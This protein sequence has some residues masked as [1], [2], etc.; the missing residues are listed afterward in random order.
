L[1]SVQ[2]EP[3]PVFVVALAGVHGAFVGTSACG[4]AVGAGAGVGLAQADSASNNIKG[5]NHIDFRNMRH[6]L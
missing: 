2:K 5:T 1:T 4:T 6:L 3:A